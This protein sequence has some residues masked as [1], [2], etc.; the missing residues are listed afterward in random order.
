MLSGQKLHVLSM[1]SSMDT[2]E[3]LGGFEQVSFFYTFI[4]RSNSV[5]LTLHLI[6]EMERVKKVVRRF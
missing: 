4:T 2:T 6:K 5:F 3:L 1:N